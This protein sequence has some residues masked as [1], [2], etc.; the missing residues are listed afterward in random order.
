MSIRL[1]ICL[2]CLLFLSCR[3]SSQ[4]KNSENEKDSLRVS[5]KIEETTENEK[6]S[7]KV[8]LHTEKIVDS[9]KE[10]REV[11]LDAKRYSEYKKPYYKLE[12][13]PLDPFWSKSI[14]RPKKTNDSTLMDNPF[15]NLLKTYISISKLD[16]SY[17]FFTQGSESDAFTLAYIG[18]TTLT[19]LD[20]EGWYVSYYKNLNFENDKYIIDYKGPFV[21]SVRLEIRIIEKINEIQVWKTTI[22]YNGVVRVHYDLKAPLSYAL[23]LPML[24][25]RN[26]RG[27]DTEFTGIDKINLE[28]LFNE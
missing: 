17:I 22:N 6:D 8:L 7:I 9:V 5:S 16:G 26:T 10:V 25:I 19:F 4:Q 3:N 14:F 2:S 1:I 21:D 23:K 12:N 24:V 20:M 15:K 27:L 11:F 18:D 13:Q 28:K